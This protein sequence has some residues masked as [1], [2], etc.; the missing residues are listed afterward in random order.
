MREG[1]K[2]VRKEGREPI[3]EGSYRMGSVQKKEL[4]RDIEEKCGRNRT[5]RRP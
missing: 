1:E 5:E 4:R 3:K 2:R